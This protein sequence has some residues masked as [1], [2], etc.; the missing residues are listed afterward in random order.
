LHCPLRH[1]LVPEGQALPHAPQLPRSDCRSAQIVPQHV[2]DP[3][4][5]MQ[6]FAVGGGW[7]QLL[8]VGL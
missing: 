3:Q 4:S 5:C 8:H 2:I 7:F 1:I 6:Q